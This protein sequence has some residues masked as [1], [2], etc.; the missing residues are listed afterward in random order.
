[1]WKTFTQAACF[2]V[3]SEI[4]QSAKQQ[5][6]FCDFLLFLNYENV[7]TFCLLI[8]FICSALNHEDPIL[9]CLAESKAELQN[10]QTRSE[11]QHNY[12]DH[13]KQLTVKT[14]QYILSLFL[15]FTHWIAFTF[16]PFIRT[17]DTGKISILQNHIM[18]QF[19]IL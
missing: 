2:R 8:I 19:Y 3:Y 9:K 14:T 5:S 6:L 4:D 15:W 12:L 7:F 18:I 13:T 16:L 17:K 11:R 1:M 10:Q